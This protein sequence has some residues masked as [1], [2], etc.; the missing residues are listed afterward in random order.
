MMVKM[1]VVETPTISQI[2]RAQQLQVEV[3]VR[4]AGLVE[5]REALVEDREAVAAT[6]FSLGV[7]ATAFSLGMTAMTRR[8]IKS[9]K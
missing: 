3:L 8:S 7:A 5:D 2:N 9:R 6:T 4:A 1:T